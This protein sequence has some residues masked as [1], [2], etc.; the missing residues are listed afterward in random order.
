MKPSNKGEKYII[1]KFRKCEQNQNNLFL[2]L[3]SLDLATQTEQQL[4]FKKMNSLLEIQ[5]N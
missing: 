1:R 3:Q 5:I 4:I 2:C